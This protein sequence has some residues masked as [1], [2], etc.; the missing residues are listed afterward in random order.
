MDTLFFIAA[1]T[2]GALIRAETWLVVAVALTVV[3]I[4]MER[5]RLALAASGVTLLGLLLLSIFPL[6][7]LLLQPLERRF[8]ANPP[9]ARVDGII[10]LG[11]AGDVDGSVYWGQTQL[12]EAGERFTAAMALAR[13]FPEARV[14]FTGG[15]GALRDLAGAP[16]SE[17]AAAETF[18]R[19]QGLEPARLL[20]E[21]K[22]RNTVENARLSLQIAEPQSEDVF[23]LITSA[24]HMPRAV[25]SF[26]AAGWP[27][28]TPYP[29][30]F[31]TSRFSSGVGWN[32][33]RNLQALNIALKEYAGQLA[34]RLT[35][36]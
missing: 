25:R 21:G 24:S 5:R 11:G 10:V 32:L 1:K 23:V 18:F 29:V 7:D 33:P 30:D 16:V 19:E 8:P 35:E 15:S 13:R 36:R 6:G 31:R 9:L 3:A 34:Y 14:L 2:L 4:L 22:S 20:L 26:E 28:L 12:N 27:A 17:A